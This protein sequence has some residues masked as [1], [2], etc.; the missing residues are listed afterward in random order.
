MESEALGHRFS[1]PEW[2]KEALSHASRRDADASL[3]SNNR[4]AY[5]GDAVIELVV[6]TRLLDGGSQP[7]DVDAKKQKEVRRAAFATVMQGTGLVLTVGKSRASAQDTPD[8]RAEAF[9]AVIGAIYRD[10]GFGVAQAAY[11]RMVPDEA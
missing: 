8:M 5:L 9:E 6:R 3:S 1:N 2:L 7:G 10:A 11:L 4:L